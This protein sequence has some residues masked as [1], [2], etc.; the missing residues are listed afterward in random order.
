MNPVNAPSPAATMSDG[1]VVGAGRLTKLIAYL[2]VCM[3]AAAFGAVLGPAWSFWWAL[4]GTFGLASAVGLDVVNRFRARRVD[5]VQNERLAMRIARKLD[6]LISNME[7]SDAIRAALGLLQSGTRNPT[8]Q[9]TGDQA[10]VTLSWDEPV[11]IRRLLWTGGNPQYRLGESLAGR[12][13]NV[14][15]NAFGLAHDK[16]L[17][18]GYVLLKCELENG[19][20]IQFVGEVLWCEPQEDRCYFSGGKILDAVAPSD[21]K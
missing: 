11:T 21:R 20:P 14:S 9:E 12:M 19:Q 6:E 4:F 8:A 3:L 13:R 1:G 16:R 15:H 7:V 10:E 17:E 18:R 5:Q 2:S